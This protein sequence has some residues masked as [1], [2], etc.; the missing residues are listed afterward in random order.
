MNSQLFTLALVEILLSISTTVVIIFVSYK[1]LKWLF[2]KNETLEGDNLAFTVFTGGIILSI[3]IILSEI[4]PSVTNVIRLS[5]HQSETLDII[6]ITKYSGLYLFIGF[7]MALLING[8]VFFLFSIL[9]KSTN[10]FKE[11][12]K[13]NLAVAILVVT[14]L[15]SITLIVKDTI[16]LLISSLVP[17]PQVTNYL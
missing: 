16:A 17:Y 13:N 8:T 5:L 3:G 15:I 6:L 12:K 14:I 1:I 4:L 7:L 11:I 2:F 10:E 9:T